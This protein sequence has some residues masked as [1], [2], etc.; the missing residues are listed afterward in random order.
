MNIQTDNQ[1]MVFRYDGQYGANYS[2]G[3]SKKKQDGTY[4]NGYMPCR[5]KKDVELENKTPIYIKQAWLTFNQKDKKTYPYIFINEFEL[6]GDK[7]DKEHKEIKK[8]IVSEQFAEFEQEI[9]L[10]DD[11]LPF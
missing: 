3:L 1:V 6:V 10:D 11:S 5:F 4:E 2:I 8:D 9:E 7:I